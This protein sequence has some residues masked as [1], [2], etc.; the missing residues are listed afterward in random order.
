MRPGRHTRAPLRLSFSFLFFVLFLFAPV[1]VTRAADFS[2]DE[3]DAFIKQ[4]LKEYGVPG[5]AV[6]LIKDD[7]VVLVRG[8]GV[9]RSGRDEL[10]DENT[11]FMIAS[12]TKPFTAAVLATLV[13]EGKLGWDDHVIDRLPEFVLPDPYPTRAATIRD[14]LAH[15][16]GLPPFAGDNLERLGFDRPEILRRI[17]YLKSTHSFREKAGYSNPG[18]LAAGMVAARVG[19]ASWEDLVKTRLFHPLGMT[20]SGVSVKDRDQSNNVAEAHFAKPD[21]EL[22]VV[23]WNNH[24]PMGPAGSIT[25]TSA[26]MAQWVRMQL[27]DGRLDGKQVI[28][29]KSIREMHTP[30]MV[31]TP[32]FAELAP[33]DQHSGFSYG[34]GWGIFYYQGSQIVEKGGAQA[35]MRSVVTLVPGKKAGIV[36]LANMNLT[37][38]PEA[39]RAKFLE[40]VVAPAGRDLQGEIRQ[41]QA[42]IKKSFSTSP[43]AKAKGGPASLPLARYAGV[44]SNDLCGPMTIQLVKDGLRWEAGPEHF[45]GPLEHVG[46]DTFSLRYPSGHLALPDDVTFVIDAGGRPHTLITESYGTLQRAP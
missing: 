30:A 42:A 46:Y 36:V 14:L 23:P 8:Y 32:T 17:R 22:Y 25:S 11:L 20:H 21:G 29:A 12:N 31:E 4:G 44:Y 15:R 33:I 26:D 18:Y 43:P 19:N 5:C 24:D 41:A 6:A 37:V 10:V 27:G 2:V 40:M 45:G 38:L 28:S 13:D 34:L 16:T 1:C 35:G 9:R 7:K 3:L 39:I